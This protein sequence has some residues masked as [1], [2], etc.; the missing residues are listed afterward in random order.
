MYNSQYS[1]PSDI[2]GYHVN[3][4]T[5]PVF[6][7][8]RNCVLLSFLEQY[9]YVTERLHSLFKEACQGHHAAYISHLLNNTPSPTPPRQFLKPRS[10][11]INS[12]IYTDR[13]LS[14][15]LIVVCDDTTILSREREREWIYIN[16]STE[17]I[18]WQLDGHSLDGMVNFSS[19]VVRASP[20]TDASQAVPHFI[21]KSNWNKANRDQYDNFISPHTR[22]WIASLKW[23]SIIDESAGSSFNPHATNMLEQYDIFL[24]Q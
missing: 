8:R 5:W 22:H 12:S 10:I 14:Y 4:Y 7:L 6:V 21:F 2:N 9:K 11:A 15:I 16:P 13:R 18:H 23:N 3:L 1:S 17:P 19:S 20:P 24:K